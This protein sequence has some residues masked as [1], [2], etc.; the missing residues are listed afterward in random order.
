MLREGAENDSKLFV[1]DEHNED[2][3]DVSLPVSET[4]FNDL[5]GAKVVGND[6]ESLD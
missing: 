5:V 1:D 2:D 6:P 3:D 4:T